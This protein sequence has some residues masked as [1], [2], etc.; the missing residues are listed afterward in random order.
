MTTKSKTKLAIVAGHGELPVKLAQSV[1]SV[2]IEPLIFALNQE[3]YQKL[4]ADFEVHQFSPVE[5]SSML[6]LAKIK[7]IKDIAFIGKVP[8]L[9]FFKNIHRL[10]PELLSKIKDLSNLNDDSLHFRLLEFLEQE[11]G[12]NVIDQTQY[13]RDYFPAEQTFTKRQISSEELEEIQY[14][15][16]MAKEIARLDIGQTVVVKN[17][18]VIAVEAIEGTNKAIKRAAKS[19]G[20][21]KDNRITVCKVSKPDQDNRFDVPTIGL[22]TVKTMPRN[23]IL[24]IEAG[25]TFF[26]D[27]KQA[28][29]LANKKNILLC[30]IK[31]EY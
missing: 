13:L 19:F 30:S 14:G 25:Q 6:E 28:I 31:V 4:I 10:D 16:K 1:R 26:V 5:V 21:F 22:E 24:A 27:Q 15:L 12:F 29:E 20:L 8:K 2:G 23:S 9:D 17:K 18:A 11:H 3:I 7:A